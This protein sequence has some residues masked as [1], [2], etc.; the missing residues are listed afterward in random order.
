MRRVS[1]LPVFLI[2]LAMA[3]P[4][5]AL[6]ASEEELYQSGLAA[7][8][9]GDAQTA[10]NLLSKAIQGHPEDHRYYNDRGVAYKVLGSREKASCRLHQGH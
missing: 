7:L 5:V 3:I 4:L 10:V 1:A 6:A 9:A 2:F 8:R